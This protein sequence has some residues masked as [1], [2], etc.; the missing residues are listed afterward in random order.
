MRNKN[1]SF[2]PIRSAMRFSTVIL[3]EILTKVIITTNKPKQQR[4]P[5]RNYLLVAMP[6]I[7]H[8]SEECKTRILKNNE[9]LEGL[10]NIF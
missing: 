9:D 4:N 7:I 1:Q 2:V 6:I 3:L 8:I 5:K 10:Q